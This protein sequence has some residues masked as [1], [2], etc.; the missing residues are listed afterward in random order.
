MADGDR[1]ERASA[2]ERIAGR[3]E[4]AEK[5]ERLEIDADDLET[6]P[7]ARLQVAVDDLA[8]RDDEEDPEDGRTVLVRTVVE[9]D[10]VEH[11]LVERD[12]EHLLGTE[13]NRVLELAGVGDAFDLE[14]RTP[15]RLLEI[16]SRMPF[17]GSLCSSKNRESALER[18]IGSRISPET[19]TPGSSGSRTAS[20]SSATPLLTTRAAAI[21]DAPILRPMSFFARFGSFAREKRRPC[22]CGAPSR[23]PR[24]PQRGR[25]GLGGRGRQIHGDS[26][27]LQHAEELLPPARDREGALD[28]DDAL[29]GAPSGRAPWSASR[30]AST[31]A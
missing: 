2:G 26:A 29:A 22:A 19:T 8:V 10:P 9:N 28:G 25:R 7:A 21:W 1:D 27:P 15:M 11:R 20:T 4:G 16:P 5:R 3:G 13:A 30:A 23:A 31:S 14:T 24:Q 17:F 18:A 6:R 12:R